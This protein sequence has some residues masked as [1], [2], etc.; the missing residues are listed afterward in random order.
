MPIEL[1]R[2]FPDAAEK[3]EIRKSANHTAKRND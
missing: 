3:R 1:E 2:F